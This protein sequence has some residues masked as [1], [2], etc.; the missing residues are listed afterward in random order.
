MKF[1][2]ASK[3][4]SNQIVELLKIALG[5]SLMPK[6]VKFWNWKHN[7]NPFGKSK[8]ILAFVC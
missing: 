1:I 3:E 4:H 5:E 2:A 7:E 8:I 6:S